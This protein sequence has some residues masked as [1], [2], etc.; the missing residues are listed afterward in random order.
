[1]CQALDL[2]VINRFGF[3]I[4]PV[5]DHVVELAREIDRRTVGQMPA[6]CQR[7]TEDGVAGLEHRRIHSKVGLRTRMRLHVG[8]FSAEQF[9]RAIDRQLLGD[10]DKLATT[11]IAFAGIALGVFIG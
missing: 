8:V 4:K 9:F 11:V 2:G 6:V 10:V 7:H 3:R 1:M 5:G